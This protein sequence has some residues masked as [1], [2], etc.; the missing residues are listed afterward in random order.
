MSSLVV[1]DVIEKS[2]GECMEH[3]CTRFLSFNRT[4][5]QGNKICCFVHK[6]LSDLFISN[7]KKYGL[8]DMVLILFNFKLAI[9]SHDMQRAQHIIIY[10]MMSNQIKCQ[11]T[12]VRIIQI[13]HKG[14]VKN[15]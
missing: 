8:Q 3:V 4:Y 10:G 9:L 5:E 13:F 2:V 12:L 6:V 15:P 11:L 1:L 14:Y 7:S